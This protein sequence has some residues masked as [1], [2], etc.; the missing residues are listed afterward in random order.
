MTINQA[1]QTVTDEDPRTAFAHA[2][3]LAGTVLAGVSRDQFELPTPCDEFDVRGLCAHLVGIL[4]LLAD[5]GRGADAQTVARA[6]IPDGDFLG[7]WAAAGRDVQEVWGDRDI[8][9][10]A[11][12]LSWTTLPGSVTM[13]IYTAEIT[14]HTWDLATATGQRPQWDDAVVTTALA[15][16]QRALPADWRSEEVPFARVVPVADDAPLID[17]LVAWTG[18]RP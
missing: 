5:V 15:T 17:Q 16:M 9:D 7:T 6:D 1:P 18:R 13:A 4:P 10:R 2:V 3:S 12:K 8:L 11:M 14:V